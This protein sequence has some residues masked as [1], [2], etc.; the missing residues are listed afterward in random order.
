MCVYVWVNKHFPKT[1][2]SGHYSLFI[3]IFTGVK[4]GETQAEESLSCGIIIKADVLIPRVLFSTTITFWVW[5]TQDQ[6][7][8]IG[9]P[10]CSA[11]FQTKHVLPFA[12]V[13][14]L[15]RRQKGQK[16]VVCFGDV[17]SLLICFF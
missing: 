17:D 1:F 6:S 2:L 15:V 9:P 14:P 3:L 11:E 13:Y 12:I 7:V 4:L 16:T 8:T 10:C 5:K